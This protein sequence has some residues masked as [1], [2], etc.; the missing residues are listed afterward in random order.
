MFAILHDGPPVTVDHEADQEEREIALTLPFVSEAKYVGRYG[1]VTARIEDSDCL[2]AALEWL[3][4]SYWLRAPE[5]R[6]REPRPRT[7]PG[8][9][10][11][12][13][14][15]GGSLHARWDDEWCL[16]CREQRRPSCWQ[17]SRS[18]EQPRRPA[19]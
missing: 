10:R 14:D 19:P 16:A 3:R 18:S 15:G 13:S 17:G 1:W 8:L 5:R 2:D 4:E 7:S 9:D 12:R 6:A 11:Y